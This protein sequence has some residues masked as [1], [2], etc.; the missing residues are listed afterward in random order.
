LKTIFSYLLIVVLA[1]AGLHGLYRAKA[2]SAASEFMPTAAIHLV[3]P[4]GTRIPAVLKNLF[5]MSTEPGDGVRAFVTD[6][7]IVNGSTAIPEG[8]RLNGIV[9]Q[10]TKIEGQAIASLR[11]NS[12]VIGQKSLPIETEPVVTNAPIESDFEILS[13]ALGTVTASGIGVAIGASGGTQGGIAA[14]MTA[15]AMRGAASMDTSNIKITVI[16]ARPLDLIR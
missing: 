16:L 12:L 11:F 7:V 4:A 8:S 6:P 14:G 5:S 1:L 3:V 2:I 13:N 10:I 15:G 9:E